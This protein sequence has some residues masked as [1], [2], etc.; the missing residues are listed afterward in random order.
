VR[1][2]AGLDAVC[3]VGKILLPLPGIEPKPSSPPLYGL[4][5]ADRM[6]KSEIHLSHCKA[7]QWLSMERGKALRHQANE[8][9]WTNKRDRSDRITFT[10]SDNG[11]AITFTHGFL[12]QCEFIFTNY[13]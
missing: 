7:G 9:T 3:G 1:P 12:R 2:R 5:Q 11:N 8:Y 4:S 13:V 6:A 10:N